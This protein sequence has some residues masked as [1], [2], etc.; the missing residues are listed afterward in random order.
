MSAKDALRE[1][2]LAARRARPEAERDAARSAIRGHVLAAAG[3]WSVVAAYEPLRTEPGSTALLSALAS[4][5]VRVLVPVT[6]PDHDLDWTVWT[7]GRTPAPLTVAAGPL[8]PDA[9][10]SADAV[11]VPAL[12]VGRDGA[13]LGRG[14]GSYDRA[15]ARV[16]PDADL[17]ALLFAGEVH[18][19][20]PADPWDVPVR[21]AVTPDGWI[22]LGGSTG[23]TPGV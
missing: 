17:A 11:L 14:R 9:V 15:L 20:V 23:A 12:A 21:A 2:L 4:R 5:G 18:D 22:A 7:P 1:R 6:R 10:A 3:A 16:R 19:T 8:G 13:R